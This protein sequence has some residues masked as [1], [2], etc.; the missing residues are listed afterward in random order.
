MDFLLL[1]LDDGTVQI[2][3]KPETDPGGPKTCR[4]YG[5]R[6]GSTALSVT[7]PER[8]LKGFS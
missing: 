3:M 4:S 5:S 8:I 7:Q 2:M 6:S 1:L